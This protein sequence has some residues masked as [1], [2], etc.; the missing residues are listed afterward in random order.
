[1]RLFGLSYNTQEMERDNTNFLSLQTTYANMI[2]NIGEGTWRNGKCIEE[3]TTIGSQEWLMPNIKGIT[4]RQE[5]VNFIHPHRFNT[6]QFQRRAILAGINSEVDSW[7]SII[8]K[9]NPYVNHK[10]H[11]LSAD[12]LAEVDDSRGILRDMLTS[13]VLNT[14]NDNGVPPHHL[15]AETCILHV[16]KQIT[17]SRNGHKFALFEKSSIRPW[18]SLCWT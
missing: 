9:V 8:Q 2:V 11:L 10:R 12:K 7:N 4:D 16:I 5:A 15:S 18:P 6:P 13:E 1:M 17:R 14:F 3:N